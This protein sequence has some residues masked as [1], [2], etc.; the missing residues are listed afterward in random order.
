MR[1]K[2]WLEIELLGR[3]LGNCW[4]YLTSDE[5]RFGTRFSCKVNVWISM[6]MRLGRN[7]ID[8]GD[9]FELFGA[10]I[11]PDWDKSKKALTDKFL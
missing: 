3:L 4:R 5:I 8:L 1:A 2:Y 9:V 11:G 7:G 10:Q 6:G